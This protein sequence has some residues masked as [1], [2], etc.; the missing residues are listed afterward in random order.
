LIDDEGIAAVERSKDERDLGMMRAVALPVLAGTLVGLPARDALAQGPSCSQVAVE[1]DASVAARWPEL[2]QRVRDAFQAREDVDRCARILLTFHEGAMA[3]AVVLPDGRSAQRSV[4]RRDDVIPV[5]E[6]LLIVPPAPPTR[7]VPSSPATSTTSAPATPPTMPH[8]TDSP[9]PTT[10]SAPV[11]EAPGSTPA[12]PSSHLRIELS[13]LTGARIGDGHASVG[14][15]AVSFLD[16]SGWLVGFAG[17]ADRYEMLDGTRSSGA[18]ELAL[19]GGRRLRFRTMALDLVGGPAV[20][21]GG[22]STYAMASKT[23]NEQ[24]ASVSNTV[25]RLLVEAR[26]VFAAMS[27]VHTFVAVD[28]DFGP[29]SSPDASQWPIAPRLPTWTAGLALGATVGTP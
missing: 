8:L 11:R 14:L 29:A 6:A 18:L 5:L 9:V 24:S 7:A 12:Q 1:A 4:S 15:G 2:T 19:L 25:P 20:A 23:G 3:V 22:T 10:A 26:L 17:R 28:G 21:L 13:V 27:T 16:L